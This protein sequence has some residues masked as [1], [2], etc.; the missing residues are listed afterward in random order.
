[1]WLEMKFRTDV[2]GLVYSSWGWEVERFGLEAL[3]CLFAGIERRCTNAQAQ[4]LSSLK[5]LTMSEFDLLYFCI[6]FP[7]ESLNIERSRN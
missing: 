6:V 3:N 5:P 4:G 2:A 1:M 7:C